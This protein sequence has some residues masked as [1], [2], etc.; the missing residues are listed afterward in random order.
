MRHIQQYTLSAG[1]GLCR[2][3]MGRPHT[4]HGLG[5]DFLYFIFFRSVLYVCDRWLKIAW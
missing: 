3:E 5:L 1:N 2:Y 4:V